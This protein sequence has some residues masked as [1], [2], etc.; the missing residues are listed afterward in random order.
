MGYCMPVEPVKYP[1]LK[2]PL[3]PVRFTIT[4]RTITSQSNSMFPLRSC[5]GR[6]SQPRATQKANFKSLNGLTIVRSRPNRRPDQLWPAAAWVA[7]TFW[8]PTASISL[9]GLSAAGSRALSA[10]C[11]KSG[12]RTNHAMDPQ[13]EGRRPKCPARSA[14]ICAR[15]GTIEIFTRLKRVATN[16]VDHVDRFL[17]HCVECRNCFGISLK[18]ALS[19][20]KVRELRGD[21]DVRGF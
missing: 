7:V 21:V 12:D 20:D 18:G 8:S 4:V 2:R 17:S 3:A 11:A 15:G 9:T 14:L 13:S 10:E 19:N 1:A 16:L 5:P 6:Q